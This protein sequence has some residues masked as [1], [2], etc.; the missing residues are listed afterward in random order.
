MVANVFATI[1]PWICGMVVVHRPGMVVV[2][3]PERI[4]ATQRS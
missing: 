1:R 4:V 2:H 3:R